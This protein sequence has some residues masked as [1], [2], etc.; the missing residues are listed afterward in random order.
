MTLLLLMTVY[1]TAIPA[2]HSHLFFY[3]FVCLF[4]SQKDSVTS[5]CHSV[6]SIELAM[7]RRGGGVLLDLQGSME[8]NLW[9]AQHLLWMGFSLSSRRPVL[10]DICF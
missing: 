7:T 5:F 4:L 6:L 10:L 8:F 2:I 1:M 9:V 3:F